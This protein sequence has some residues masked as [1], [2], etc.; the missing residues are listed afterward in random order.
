MLAGNVRSGPSRWPGRVHIIAGVRAARYGA[1][2]HTTG[3]RSQAYRGAGRIEASGCADPARAGSMR[4]GAPCGRVRTRA[5][6]WGRGI[7]LQPA[8][9]A[10]FRLASSVRG[11][12]A[13]RRL[14]LGPPARDRRAIRAVHVSHVSRRR[15]RMAATMAPRAAVAVGGPARAEATWIRVI[16]SCPQAA[17]ESWVPRPDRPRTDPWPAPAATTDTV[18]RE[19]RKSGGAYWLERRGCRVWMPRGGWAVVCAGVPVSACGRSAP[20]CQRRAS[21]AGLSH[22][23]GLAPSAITSAS[24]SSAFAPSVAPPDIQTLCHYTKAPW[25]RSPRLRGPGPVSR[26]SELY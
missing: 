15:R 4:T 20:H 26:D 7:G 5:A 1:A 6:Q 2:S 16:P 25:P 14:G 12:G 22:R 24:S 21:A 8:N 17:P 19:S 11:V 9:P 3:T 18:S 23:G 13:A 10:G